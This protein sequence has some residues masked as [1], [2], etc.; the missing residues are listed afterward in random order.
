MYLYRAQKREGNA[1][2]KYDKERV[3]RDA[4]EKQHKNATGK[5]KR[6]EAELQNIEGQLRQL[7]EAWERMQSC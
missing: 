1:N 4:F 3:H 7:S 5:T 6:V 2:L